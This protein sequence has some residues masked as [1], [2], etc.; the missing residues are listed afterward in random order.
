MISG[1][2]A[3]TNED[4]MPGAALLWK[5]E[6]ALQGGCR[7]LQYRNKHGNPELRQQEAAELRALCKRY[8]A[9]LIINDSPALAAAVAADGA[10]IGQGDTPLAAARKILGDTAIIGVTCHASLELAEQAARSGANYLAFGRF[11]A[12]QTKPDAPPASIDLLRAAR[13]FHLPLVAI[14]G[15]NRDNARLLVSAGADCLAVSHEIFNSD[16]P[17]EIRRRAEYFTS[18]F[19]P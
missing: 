12:S 1:L 15:I 17:E 18:L 3:I 19:T 9:S 2:Y 7:L 6:A 14:G 16:D 10:H 4:L 5:T 11:F 8:D 13:D